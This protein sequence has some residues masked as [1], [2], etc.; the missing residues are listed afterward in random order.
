MPQGETA[1]RE[2]L[3]EDWK[4]SVWEWDLRRLVK[5]MRLEMGEM[6]VVLEVM[7]VLPPLYAAPRRFWKR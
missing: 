6:R 5:E 2:M 1:M 7:T 4:G 3:L